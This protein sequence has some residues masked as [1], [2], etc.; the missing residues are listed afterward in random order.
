MKL[1]TFLAAATCVGAVR[2]SLEELQAFFRQRA[3]L[4]A[5]RS[6]TLEMST[7]RKKK[8]EPKECH[9]IVGG[10]EKRE[11]WHMFGGD[12]KCPNEHVVAGKSW[13]CGDALGHR[14]FSNKLA[15]SSCTC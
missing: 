7:T 10:A 5:N 6:S 8:E 12:C 1:L 4:D 3:E 14:H 2:T 15:P 13:E 11:R 9:E